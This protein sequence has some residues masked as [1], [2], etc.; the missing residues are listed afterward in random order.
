MYIWAMTVHD[1]RSASPLLDLIFDNDGVGRC[2]VAP[3]AS[4]LR[5][6]AAWLRSTGFKRDE[7]LGANIVEL[8]PDSRD[9]A[10]ALH[11]RARAGHRV[12]VPRHAHRR[13]REAW[14]EGTMTRSPW[15]AGR[16][17]S[18]RRGR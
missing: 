10:L 9:L 14:W 13:G 5:A 7:V 8:F 18:S 4:V 15:K 16:A 11:A 17:C 6:N 12:E 1:V 3:D 2:L